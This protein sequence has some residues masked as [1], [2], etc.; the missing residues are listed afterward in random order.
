[1]RFLII[2]S[3]MFSLI[4]FTSPSSRAEDDT[5]TKK[6]WVGG[7][8]LMTTQLTTTMMQQMQIIGTFFDAKHQLETQ[9]LFQEKTAQAHKDYHPSE[10]MC[11][12][13]TFVRNLAES[14]KRAKL[15]HTAFTQGMIDRALK[16]GDAKTSGISMDDDTRLRGYI[17]KF[18][19]V[20]DNA[21]QNRRL[22]KSSVSADKQNA[23][24]NYTKTIDLP[25][26]LD[27]NMTDNDVDNDEENI[28]AFLDY[29]FM[30][31]SFPWIEQEKTTLT[32]FI[33]PY[34]D[35]RS[36]IAMRSVAQNSFAYIISEKSRGTD[37]TQAS[38]APYIKA[39][40]RDL[41]IDDDD[42]KDMLGEN[43]SYYAQMEMLTKKIY[44]HPEFMSNLYD[45]PANVKRI[46]AALTAIKTMQ[47]RDIHQAMLRREML[48]S[49]MLELN[50]RKRQV[51]VDRRV[52]SANIGAINSGATSNNG[53]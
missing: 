20:K 24:I 32:K 29:I 25:L 31:D 50:L 48:M 36:L 28:F 51:D 2:F 27:I 39:L 34:Q 14:E 19:S 43:P 42:I 15:S 49:M 47:D 7:L 9:R 1:M 4:F 26:T 6:N 11:E 52:L 44:Q 18:C 38:A 8:Q 22:C 16:T 5:E 3:L 41:G 30:H 45:K 40:M 33:E 12:I 23:D 35:M 10:Q 53:F 21:A 17:E 13:G 37:D 46:K